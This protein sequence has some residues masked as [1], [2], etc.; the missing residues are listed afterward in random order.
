MTATQSEWYLDSKALSPR[1]L[2]HNFHIEER[3]VALPRYSSRIGNLGGYSNALETYDF[4][5]I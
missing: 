3:E 2:A 1:A 5:E 4:V